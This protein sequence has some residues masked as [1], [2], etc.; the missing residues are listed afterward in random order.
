MKMVQGV[1]NILYYVTCYSGIRI[2]ENIH[3]LASCVSFI[4]CYDLTKRL[5]A[6]RV[7]EATI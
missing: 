3:A 7:N 5:M 6:V 1:K 2:T 4:L